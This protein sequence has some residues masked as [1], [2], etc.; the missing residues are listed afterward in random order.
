MA[1]VGTL[2]V[3]VQIV[4][5]S[6]PKTNEAHHGIAMVDSHRADASIACPQFRNHL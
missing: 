2:I 1:S 3:T 6:L 5:A 4:P